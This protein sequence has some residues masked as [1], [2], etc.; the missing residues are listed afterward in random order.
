M[1]W[2]TLVPCYGRD[3]KSGEEVLAHWK[4]GK[5]FRI[6]DMSCPWDGAA[7]SSRDFDNRSAGVSYDVF[8][9]RYKKLTKFVLIKKVDGEWKIAK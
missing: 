8:K 2:L 1:K 4:E 9:I 7:T 5:D 6:M 3:Y